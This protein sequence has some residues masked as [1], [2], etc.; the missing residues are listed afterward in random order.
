[1]DI[2]LTHLMKTVCKY[3]AKLNM[4]LSNLRTIDAGGLSLFAFVLFC[5]VWFGLGLIWFCLLSDNLM[6]FSGAI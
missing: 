2:V 6:L 5:L 1:M 4:K 3:W